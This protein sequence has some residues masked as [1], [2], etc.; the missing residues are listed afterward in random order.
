[1]KKQSAQVIHVVEATQHSCF[2]YK[3]GDVFV[4]VYSPSTEV[5]T[6]AQINWYL[7]AAKDE[8]LDRN[9]I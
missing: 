3:E 1:M 5:L 8:L 6:K 4:T 2:V 9:N 7:D